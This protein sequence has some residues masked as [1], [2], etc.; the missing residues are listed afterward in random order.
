MKMIDKIK[1]IIGIKEKIKC[2]CGNVVTVDLIL[3]NCHII[4]KVRKKSGEIMNICCNGKE[5]LY[6]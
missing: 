5:F 1:K 3:E 2:S 4:G 6:N